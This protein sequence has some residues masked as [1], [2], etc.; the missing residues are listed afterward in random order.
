VTSLISLDQFRAEVKAGRKPDGPVFRVAVG[1]AVAVEGRERTKRFCFSDG[2]VDR[3][4]DTIAPDGWMIDEFLSN[5]VALWAHDSSAPPIGKASNLGVEFDRLMGDIEF[6][7]AEVYPF[8]DTI[9]RLL[10]GDFLR[11]VS[12]GFIPREYSF[13][14]ND[15]DRGWGIDFKKQVLLEI[16]VCPVPANPNA[17]AEARAKGIDTRPLVA[18]AEA[19]LDAGG[20]A[21]VSKAELNRLRKLAKEPATMPRTKVNRTDDDKP[22]VGNCGRASDDECGMK[23]MS[24]CSVHGKSSEDDEDDKKFL[25]AIRKAL[26][27]LG[28]PVARTADDDNPEPGDDGDGPPIEHKDAIR[29]AHRCLRTAKALIDEGI[30]HHKKGM[31]MLDQVKDA[32]DADAG[33]PGGEGNA[34]VDPGEKAAHLAMVRRL[35]EVAKV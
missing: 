15:P 8:A 17:L 2:S 32:I 24:Q 1:K 4:G 11:A 19:A 7:T 28:I 14:E 10:D 5:P 22:V 12:V 35:R 34:E 26:A 30:I 27:T 18:W 33:D 13:V 16:S 25:A 6:A 3:M 21:V 9:Y 31:D 29:I 23:D 20:Q